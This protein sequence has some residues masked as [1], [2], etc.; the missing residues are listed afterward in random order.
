M[1][2]IML[3]A[4]LMTFL[5]V[6]PIGFIYYLIHKLVHCLKV[7]YFERIKPKNSKNVEAINAVCSFNDETTNL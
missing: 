7:F 4:I 3:I 5:I 6:I 1:L 2:E